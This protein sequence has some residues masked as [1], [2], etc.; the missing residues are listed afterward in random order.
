MKEQYDVLWKM[1]EVKFGSHPLGI[2]GKNYLIADFVRGNFEVLNCVKDKR[3]L[4]G[5]KYRVRF[6]TSDYDRMKKFIEEY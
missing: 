4:C 3:C 5:Y 6:R 1:W 2:I